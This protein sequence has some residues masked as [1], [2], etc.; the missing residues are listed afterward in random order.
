MMHSIIAIIAGFATMALLVI[1]STAAATRLML[2]SA[3]SD[4]SARPTGAYLAV[5][6]S[7]S[8]VFAA[9]GGYISAAI[10]TRAPLMH[11][12]IL[13]GF[14][15]LMGLMSLPQSW[16]KQPKWYSITICLVSP[17]CVIAGGLLRS[18]QQGG[19]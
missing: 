11:A 7:Y 13:A 8:L 14:V 18:I 15:L 3:M 6:L 5:N 17:I 1:I 9:L 16:G 10:A 4:T 12:L 2:G 19:Q